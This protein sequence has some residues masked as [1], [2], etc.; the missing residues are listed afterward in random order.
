MAN[1]T[2]AIIGAS[3]DRRKFGN[4][5]VR[6]HLRAGYDVYPVN[7]NG[8]TVPVEKLDR[9]SV[10]LPPRVGLTVLDEIAEKGCKE[11]WLNP[12]AD[13]EEVVRKARS[14]GLNVIQSCSIVDVGISPYELSDQ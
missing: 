8:G 9:V 4:K 6:A 3:D 11:L 1:P 12:G 10:Y 14:L 2:V 13:S 5:S 7:I